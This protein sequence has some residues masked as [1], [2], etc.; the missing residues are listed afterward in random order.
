MNT[1]NPHG[2]TTYSRVSKFYQLQNIDM[3]EYSFILA[4][5]VAVGKTS[6]YRQLQKR[7]L[8]HSE[9]YSRGAR[10]HEDLGLQQMTI[11]MEIDNK[12]IKVCPL[13]VGV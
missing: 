8:S 12:D 7:G 2:K 13:G 6:I 10:I 9:E 5:R 3:R 1:V 4:G 11:E